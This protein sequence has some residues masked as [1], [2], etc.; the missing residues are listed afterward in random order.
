MWVDTPDGEMK[1][2]CHGTLRVNGLLN[3]QKRE[4]LFEGT[5]YIPDS[6]VTLVSADKL[7]KR[8]FFWDMFTDTLIVKETGQQIYEIKEHY[9]LSIIEHNP[10]SI[11]IGFANLVKPRNT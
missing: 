11:D 9:R 2:H 1:I 3:G 5:A 4:L 8:G 7:K 6:S 10:E